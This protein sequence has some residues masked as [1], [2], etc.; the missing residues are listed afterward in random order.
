MGEGSDFVG[1]YDVTQLVHLERFGDIERA[2][3]REK[4]LKAWKRAW[5]LD[6][7]RKHNPTWEDLCDDACWNT[8]GTKATLSRGEWRPSRKSALRRGLLSKPFVVRAIVI[9]L[10][11]GIGALDDGLSTDDR[12]RAPSWRRPAS[13]ELRT[14]ENSRA[15]TAFVWMVRVHLLPVGSAA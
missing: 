2:I 1:Q 15:S 6:L 4:Q 11:G 3:R 12:A 5:K 8:G 13:E 10:G 14:A 9:P 7:I